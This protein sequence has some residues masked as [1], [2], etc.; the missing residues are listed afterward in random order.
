M[1]SRRR[2]HLDSF[3]REELNE[4]LGNV[5]CHCQRRIVRSIPLCEVRSKI[6][7]RSRLKEELGSRGIAIPGVLLGFCEYWVCQERRQ[8]VLVPCRRGRLQTDQSTFRLCRVIDAIDQ[9][10]RAEV[11]Q[12]LRASIETGNVHGSLKYFESMVVPSERRGISRPDSG[13]S[14]YRNVLCVGHNVRNS[15]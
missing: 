4:P 10:F 7:N 8:R 2:P 5:V 6:L 3:V 14:S 15:F 13:R 12:Q 11:S 1:P 9:P